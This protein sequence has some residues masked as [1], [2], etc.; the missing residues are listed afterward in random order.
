MDTL[1]DD[2]LKALKNPDGWEV[3]ATRL[4]HPKKKIDLWMANGF[5]FFNTVDFPVL[6][7]M[8][9]IVLWPAAKRLIRLIVAEKIKE[10]K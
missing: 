5:F 4:R 2:L 7:I 8:D 1:R 9:Q 10:G 3:T 6:T